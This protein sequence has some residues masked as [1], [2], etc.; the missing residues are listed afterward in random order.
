VRKRANMRLSPL[1]LRRLLPASRYMHEFGATRENLAE[2]AVAAHGWARLNPEA[3]ERGPLT[4]ENVLAARL[5]S[6][7]LGKLDCC[8]IKDGAAAV[9]MTRTDCAKGRP[10]TPVYLLG[11]AMGITIA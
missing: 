6:D 10:K 5:I 9:V 11:A 3:F 2:V 7:P 4:A 8:L 1:G